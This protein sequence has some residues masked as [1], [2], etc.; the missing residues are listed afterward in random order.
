MVVSL[1]DY[2]C[3]DCLVGPR[4][5]R[6]DLPYYKYLSE[7]PRDQGRFQVKASLVA[8]VHSAWFMFQ[9]GAGEMTYEVMTECI[10]SASKFEPETEQEEKLKLAAL[11]VLTQLK[12]CFKEKRRVYQDELLEL[13]Q[14]GQWVVQNVVKELAAEIS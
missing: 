5:F 3:I 12:I 6:F 7:P 8:I 13:Y 1:S 14:T 11:K 4:D 9:E 10:E 2:E